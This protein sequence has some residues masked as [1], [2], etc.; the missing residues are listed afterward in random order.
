MTL[1]HNQLV[2]TAIGKLVKGLDD[3]EGVP[4]VVAQGIQDIVEAV[5]GPRSADI[6]KEC[7]Q[8]TEGRWYLPS[9][10]GLAVWHR[11]EDVEI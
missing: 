8:T 1:R 7:V 9:G 3:D 4:T 2:K 6:F 10:Q 11:M 5:M